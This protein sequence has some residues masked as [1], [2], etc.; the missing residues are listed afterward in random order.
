VTGAV[1]A[2]CGV[3]GLAVGALLPV[4]TERVP[5]RVPLRRRPFP[6]I[7]SSLA[8]TGG[9]VLVVGTGALFAA[10]GLRYGDSWALPAFLLFA[11]ALVALSVIDLQHFLLPNRIIYPVTGASLVL[12]AAAA[13]AADDPDALWRCLACAVGAFAV[14]L[15]LH[16]ASPRAMG[17]GDVRLAFLLGLVLGWL[18]AGEV[19][20]GLLLGF[21]YGAVLGVVLLATGRRSRHDHIP[22]GPFLAA[23]A[24]TALL[25]GE[26]ILDWYAG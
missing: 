18:G 10:I 13:V 2:A 9:R 15:V 16:L 5:E 21:V 6:E 22:F 7:R 12:L 4:V 20:L 26:T 25:V 3:L 1:A 19:V 11:A 17:F 8:T 23:G 24:L 14:F